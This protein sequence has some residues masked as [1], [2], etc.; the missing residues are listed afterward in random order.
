MGKSLLL[1]FFLV[2]YNLKNLLAN[3]TKE[4][5]LNGSHFIINNVQ[6]TKKYKTMIAVWI[7]IVYKSIY[8]TNRK[9]CFYNNNRIRSY[10]IFY[11][12]K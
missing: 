9:K 6:E 2:I 11:V 12:K 8:E 10:Q 4:T 5:V 1:F 7:N 3:Y